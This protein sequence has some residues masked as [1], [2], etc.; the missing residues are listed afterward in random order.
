MNSEAP[1]LEQLQERIA[2]LE[3]QN[4]W[5]K[6]CGALALASV[7]LLAIMAQ[8]PSATRKVDANEITIRDAKGNIRARIGVDATTDSAEMWLQTAKGDIGTSISQNGIV[9]KQDGVARTILG[10]SSITL[11]NSKGQP[12]VRI[13]AAD[14]AERDLFIEGSTG[15]LQYLPGHALEVSDSDG[16]E[17]LIGT[18]DVHGAAKAGGQ[19][20][21]ASVVL[22][23]PDRKVLWKAP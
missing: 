2:K 14:D 7:A 12:N 19:T 18:T 23:D 1:S 4:L 10:D 20:S 11:T 17:A 6:R 13:T 5:F 9:M 22:T 3:A 15:F 16:Y 8:A 21:A